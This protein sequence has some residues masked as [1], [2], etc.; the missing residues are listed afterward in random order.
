MLYLVGICF[1]G[2]TSVNIATKPTADWFKNGGTKDLGWRWMQEADALL[3]AGGGVSG[4]LGT[5][6]IFYVDSGVVNAGDGSNWNNAKATIEEAYDLCTA[7]AG[8]VILV[9]QGHSETLGTLVLDTEG[10]TIVGLGQGEDR[11]EIV[12][13]GTGDIITISGASNTL[14][15]LSFR[16]GVHAIVTGIN[17]TGDGDYTTIA[18]CDFPEPSTNTFDFITAIQLTTA[19]DYVTVQDCTYKHADAV[20]PATFIDGGASV[21]QGLSIINNLVHG[22]F[23]TAIINSDQADT[24]VFIKGNTLTNM[25]TTIP[26]ILFSAAATGFCEDNT[27]YTDTAANTLDPGSM[28]CARNYQV[29]AVDLSAVLVPP[30]PAIATVTAGSADDILKKMY[31]TSDGT[32]AYPATVA[33]DST[34]A[35]IMAK[36]STATASTFD[37]TTDSL[38]AISDLITAKTGTFY[39]GTASTNAVTTTVISADLI[40]FGDAFFV[41]DWVMV[42]T[43]DAGGAAGAPEGEVRDISGY[44]SSTGTFTVTAFSAAVTANDKVQVMRRENFAI[45]MASLK[46]APATGSLATFIASGGTSLG[47]AL[48][49]STSLYDVVKGLYLTACGTGVYPTGVT[50]DS[51]LAMVLSKANPAAASSYSNTTDSLEMLSDKLGAFAGTAGAGATESIYSLAALMHTDI[52]SILADTG[53]DGVVLAADAITAAK[54]AADAITTAELATGCVSADEIA[55][56]AIGTDEIAANAI[57]AS[58]IADG[59]IDAGALATACIT[60][61]EIDADAIGADELASSAVTEIW[62]NNISAYSGAGYAGTYL[63]TVYDDW[64]NGGRLDLILD[65]IAADTIQIADGTLPASPTSG[66]LATF[67]ASGGTALG[68]PLATSKSLV[69]ALGTNGTT[70]ADTATGIAGLIGKPDDADNATDSTTIVSNADGSVFERL[71]YLQQLTSDVLSQT[72]SSGVGNIFYVDSVTGSDSDDGTTWAG[73]EATISAALGD[74]TANKGDIILVAPNHTET[75]A[76][77]QLTLN[78]IGVKIIGLGVGN[79]RP[80]IIFNNAAASWD[81]TVA[82][83]WLENLIFRADADDVLIGLHYVDASHYCTIKKCEFAITSTKEFLTA[84]QVD[85]G[86]DVLTIDECEFVSASAGANY[87][88]SDT[89]GICD[90]LTI[91]NCH[92]NGDYAVAAIGSDQINTNMLIANNIVSNVN[93]GNFPIELTAAA[94]GELTDNRLYSNAFATGLDPGSLKCTGNLFVDA[95]DESGYPIPAIGDRTDN[96]VGTNSANND[97]V[98]SAVVSNADG[99]I[100]ERQESVQQAA[101]S[102][103]AYGGTNYLAVTVTFDGTTGAGHY[104]KSGETDEILTVTG[105]VQLRILPVCTTDLTG[106]DGG[107]I[108]LWGGTDVLIPATVVNTEGADAT[109]LE[110]GELWLDTSPTERVAPASTSFFNFVANEDDIGLD[111]QVQDIATGVI[112]FH[113][114]WTPLNA[115]GNVV[116]GAGGAL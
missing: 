75:L 58:E 36:G 46:I 68:T 4:G 14:V 84:V 47:T 49:A 114:W 100:L 69:D 50:D 67:I 7:N 21:T 27:M 57:G 95:I 51:I 41:T 109:F 85:T 70:I 89:V 99:S 77:A 110:Q 38:E 2:S 78:K 65:I 101:A 102:I 56:D 66:S 13:N 31:Y 6:T 8:D 37:N 104:G 1:A 44:T 82:N 61:A 18:Y 76:A 22:E 39:I 10:V 91:K 11:P 111:C 79:N 9:A 105:A 28:K 108:A 35:K 112:V 73:A 25:T 80:T 29:N 113:V 71:E 3:A 15:N 48:P 19:A 53:T 116:A 26:A 32:D 5:G 52:D 64:L 43:Y 23:S 40:G 45:D 103:P 96:Y 92:I 74:C 93:A 90:R 24:E 20:G 60:S 87:A 54:I 55:T 16:A 88:I 12:F 97:A 30:V 86:A 72:G 115:T 81:I 62:Q 83:V 34:L 98:S 107:T 33:N 59:A 63:K 106:T 94:T 17:I 42:C